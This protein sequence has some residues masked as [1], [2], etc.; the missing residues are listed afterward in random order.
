MAE[1]EQTPSVEMM[2]QDES[3]GQGQPEQAASQESEPAAAVAMVDSPVAEPTPESAVVTEDPENRVTEPIL[4]AQ[5]HGTEPV[6]T[7]SASDPVG[8]ADVSIAKPESDSEAD[9]IVSGGAEI[10]ESVPVAEEPQGS[11]SPTDTPAEE[12]AETNPVSEPGNPESADPSAVGETEPVV[13]AVEDASTAIES[14]TSSSQD[15]ADEDVSEM[16]QPENVE[17]IPLDTPPVPVDANVENEAE[18]NPAIEP[19]SVSPLPV[20]LGFLPVQSAQNR[21]GYTLR[22]LF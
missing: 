12:A 11:T 2:A 10:Q 22:G 9:T 3:V 15:V 7:A 20:R 6:D 21:P 8:A 14:A 17:D 5:G 16:E 18:E 19:L 13:A 1:S 4:D